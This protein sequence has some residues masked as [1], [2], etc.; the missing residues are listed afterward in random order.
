M[1]LRQ[2]TTFIKVAQLG[3]FSNAADS[4]GYSQSAVTV[5]IRQL[6]DELGTR[7]FDRMGKRIALTDPGS[8]FLN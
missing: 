7:L 6:E 1:E 3:S 8:Q 2:I 5:Q 4:L